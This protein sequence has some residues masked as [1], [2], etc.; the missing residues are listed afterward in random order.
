MQWCDAQGTPASVLAL[1]ND[2]GKNHPRR[3]QVIIAISC[4]GAISLL[5]A[6]GD[7]AGI[8]TTTTT[9]L[10]VRS[11]NAF[12]QAQLGVDGPEAYARLLHLSDPL[13]LNQL[14]LLLKVAALSATMPTT[15]ASTSG[16]G[17]G[18]AVP[19][20]LL[21]MQRLPHVAPSSGGSQMP[22]AGSSL[23]IM[24]GGGQPCDH[25]AAVAPQ[26]H[27]DAASQPHAAAAIPQPHAAPHAAPKPL[28]LLMRH[29]VPAHGHLVGTAEADLRPLR[30]LPAA[31]P[32]PAA[33]AAGAGASSAGAGVAASRPVLAAEARVVASEGTVATT[34]L[35][36][37]TTKSSPAGSVDKCGGADCLLDH[38]PDILSLC[39]IGGNVIYQV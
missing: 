4:T 27:A 3:R 10:E 36:T 34:T 30:V 26:P 8:A 11:V 1:I 28:L 25:A 6:D 7:T 13:G 21:P 37:L 33:T 31:A 29:V 24:A 20:T 12:A 38:V 19:H 9:L 22:L 32:L 15:I 23:E 39:L 18:E 35:T 16:G 2:C 17:A 14:G 5:P